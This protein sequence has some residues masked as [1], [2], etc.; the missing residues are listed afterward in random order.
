MQQGWRE[1]LAAMQAAVGEQA[2]Q[3]RQH[4]AALQTVLAVQQQLAQA[5]VALQKQAQ[6]AD[7][8][9]AAGDD[10]VGLVADQ[11]GAK[12]GQVNT[13]GGM[14]VRK[15]IKVN[16]CACGA[17]LVLP[18]RLP[19]VSNPRGAGRMAAGWIP[20]RGPCGEAGERGPASAPGVAAGGSGASAHLP[21]LPSAEGLPAGW[22]GGCLAMHYS[23]TRRLSPRPL[24]GIASMPVGVTLQ[25]TSLQPLSL[26]GQASLPCRC[27]RSSR[28][29]CSSWEMACGAS[30]SCA[31]SCRQSWK[32]CKCR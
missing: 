26:M 10:G 11:P 19:C 2:G 27:R 17:C 9:A 20:G 21:G 22:G 32:H 6:Q 18:L 14:H 4:D 8:P 31:S 28:A 1:L 24:I 29:P 16:V 15:H 23:C 25:L 5:L 13:Q 7:K 12:D 30:G 3:L